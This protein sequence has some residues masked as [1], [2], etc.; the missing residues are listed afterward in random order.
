MDSFLNIGLKAMRQHTAGYDA[1][2][3]QQELDDFARPW[4]MIFSLWFATVLFGV[5]VAASFFIAGSTIW[6]SVGI[7]TLVGAVPLPYLLQHHI[8]ENLAWNVV[9]NSLQPLVTELQSFVR[10]EREAYRSN[11]DIVERQLF[12]SRIAILLFSENRFDRF[13][14]LLNPVRSYAT[15]LK[16]EQ[17]D[18]IA[19]E[20][21][22]KTVPSVIE[23]PVNVVGIVRAAISRAQDRDR[24]WLSEIDQSSF[25]IRLDVLAAKWQRHEAAGWIYVYT[26]AHAYFSRHPH[27]PVRQCIADIL[28]AKKHPAVI[29]L[30][31]LPTDETLKVALS[32]TPLKTYDKNRQHL[33][34]KI[35]LTASAHGDQ[36]PLGY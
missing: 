13:M 30:S 15:L 6:F 35:D 1:S 33:E 34:G 20:S 27:N 22:E 3:L 10:G 8:L 14:I 29:G 23:Q 24:H 19:D 16:A 36:I 11:G 4:R 25:R 12:R 7:I 17:L 18:E 2:Q 21:P 5:C 31:K 28:N 32:R 26:Q 9:P